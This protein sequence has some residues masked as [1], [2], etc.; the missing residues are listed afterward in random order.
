MWQLQQ[1]N[2]RMIF[3]LFFLLLFYLPLPLLGQAATEEALQKA[4]TCY[5][6]I[7]FSKL[8]FGR[9]SLVSDSCLQEALYTNATGVL[10]ENNID[11]ESSTS[12]WRLAQLFE[13]YLSKSC[14]GFQNYAIR[15]AQK[16]VVRARDS[17]PSIKGLLYEL[18]NSGQF[19]ILS[20]IAEDRTLQRFYWLDEFDGSTRF[21]QGLKKYR[22]TIVEVY[23]KEEMLYDSRQKKYLNSKKI[24]LIDEGKTLENNSYKKWLDEFNSQK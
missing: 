4:C 3:R 19:P 22:Q 1:P 14:S 8:A 24:V 5:T 6:S 7:D 21:M 10:E 23:W 16:N 20:V 11:L 2:Q 13:Q 15:L 18:D 12:M 9:L 17:Y